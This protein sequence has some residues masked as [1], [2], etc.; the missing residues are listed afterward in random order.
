M[1]YKYLFFLIVAFYCLVLT[2]FGFENFD[3]GYI[4]SFAW[5]V[6]NGQHIY[7]DFLYKGPPATIY[8]HAFL[9][10]IL[11]E[12]GQF[13][14]IRIIVYLLFALQVYLCVSGFYAIYDLSKLKINK[15]GIMSV[16]FIISL[17]NFSPYPWP[18]TD[19]LL[20]ASIAFWLVCKFRSPNTM[21]LFIIAFFS[22]LAAITK[23]SFYSLPFA[24][25]IW[26]YFSHGLKKA[27]IQIIHY[28]ILT[29]AFFSLILSITTLKNFIAQ[30]TGETSLYQLFCTGLHNYIFMPTNWFLFLLVL[31]CTSAALYLLISKQKLIAL[32]PVLKWLSLALS[33]LAIALGLFKQ[34]PLAS[35]IAFDACLIAIV[36]SVLF[37]RKSIQYLMPVLT[38]LIIAWSAGISL[39]Y[40]FPILYGTGII[41]SFIVLLKDDIA[42]KPK[43]YKCLALPL[44]IV[45][46]SYNLKPYREAYI[47]DLGYPLE[48]ISPKL[49]FIKSTKATFEKYS[50]LKAL[51]GKYGTKYIV[52]PNIPMTHYLFNENSV[53]PA[54]W[55]INSEVNRRY[56]LFIK[57]ASA[58]EN[59]VFLEKSFLNHEEYMPAKIE[60]FS[61]ISWYIFKNFKR[62][63]ET[64]YFIVYNSLK[65]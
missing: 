25:T 63:S 4:S 6:I 56:D 50:E 24:F 31:L 29:V 7:Q 53:L 17:L 27:L 3:T 35:R 39:G 30:T 52:A 14:F 64:K 47:F 13:F 54:D 28:F 10:K 51:I 49:K 38:S 37:H 2:Q 43:Y 61:Y 33:T 15:W 32:F 48:S 55:I 41:M 5:R 8:F 1:N 46:F 40:Q 65:E 45:A 11:P 22:F 60:E 36:Y 21:M 57:L 9:I 42:V 19:G 20:F 26:I 23:Q 12:T 62:V 16:C 34:L 44:C 18:T 58:K 59:Y